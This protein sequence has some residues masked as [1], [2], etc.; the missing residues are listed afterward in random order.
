MDRR[1]GGRALFDQFGI[2]ARKAM[3]VAGPA[4]RDIVA[5]AHDECGPFVAAAVTGHSVCFALVFGASGGTRSD[6]GSALAWK[7]AQ[8]SMAELREFGMIGLWLGVTFRLR[9]LPRSGLRG[10]RGRHATL[11]SSKD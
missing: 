7:P 3:H 10:P 4:C 5:L 6:S 11:G 8:T 9:R 2:A 1:S